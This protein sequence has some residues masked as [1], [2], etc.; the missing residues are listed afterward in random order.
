MPFLRHRNTRDIIIY[1]EDFA[2]LFRKARE[3]QKTIL[4]MVYNTGKRL[5][6]ILGL[7]WESVHQREG[8][9]LA[10]LISSPWQNLVRHQGVGASNSK[11]SISGSGPARERH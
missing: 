6:E 11:N 3:P 4:L 9:K 7:R 10:V 5:E 2:L 8:R 1:E